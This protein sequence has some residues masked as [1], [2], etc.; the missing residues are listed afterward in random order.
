MSK[1]TAK[2]VDETTVEI[3][4]D[5]ELFERFMNWDSKESAQ[6]Y[7]DLVPA[8]YA[9]EEEERLSGEKVVAE[10]KIKLEKF[11]TEKQVPDYVTK[12]ALKL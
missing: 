3:Y 11:L 7:A 1:Y 9:K 8:R 2:V 12:E 5:D 6:N 4:K 10:F